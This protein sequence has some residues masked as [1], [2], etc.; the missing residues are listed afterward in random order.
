MNLALSQSELPVC[1]R[2]ERPMTDEEFLRFCAANEP[3]RVE[4]EANGEIVVMSPAGFGTGRIN[5][6]ITR[7]LDE[8][9]EADGRGAVTDSNAGYAL[10]DGSVRAPDA[11]WIS[12]RRLESL[13]EEQKTGFPPVCPDFIIELRSPSDK[14]PDLQ[15]K[16]KQWIANG[17]EVGWLIDP[18]EKAVTIYRPG[19]Q[20]EHLAQP[21]SVQ[22][23]GPIA[24]FE[25]VLAR[26]WA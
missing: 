3:M 18:K 20:T 17:V 11:A 19:D 12:M 6:R 26:I 5:S 23:T 22:G 21:T 10:P 8:W 9:A 15:E 13:S 4:R 16:M 1:L 14:L 7:C 24:G 2:F 25:L